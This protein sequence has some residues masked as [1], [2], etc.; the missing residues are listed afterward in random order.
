LIRANEHDQVQGSTEGRMS[1]REFVLKAVGAG[2]AASS[3]GTLLT[4]C[5][6]GL[7]TDQKAQG[8]SITMGSSTQGLSKKYS[9]QT[10]AVALAITSAGNSLLKKFTSQTGIK[11]KWTV[12]GWDAL[13]NKITA[14]ASADTYF[15]DV[16]D[17]DWSRVGLYARTKWFAPLKFSDLDTLKKDVPQLDVFTVDGQLVGMPNDASIMVTTVNTKD[18]EQAGIEKMPTT[19]DAYENALKDIQKA[20]VNAHPLGI[21]FAA[22]EG[23]STYWYQLTGGAFGGRILSDSFKP[24]FTDKSSAGYRAM[25]WMVEQYKSGMV[26]K[27]YINVT[28]SSEMQSGMALHKLSSIFSDYSGNVSTLYNVPSQSKVTGQI[29]Y[30]PTPGENGIGQNLGNPDGVGI[31]VTARRKGAAAQFIKWYTSTETQAKLAG[32]YGPVETG[33]IA[34]PM[35]LSSMK[36]LAKNTSAQ[37]AELLELFRDN[38]RPVFPG[39]PP[40]WYPTFSDAVYTNIHS[41]ALGQKTVAQAIK[42]IARTVSKEGD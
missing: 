6:G 18:F 23:L 26:P 15:A 42:E 17:V 21:P 19:F 16:T 1:R 11:V 39:G 7:T 8:Q 13:Q 35:R 28:D 27:E 38:S 22:A 36:I 24:L 14:A 41:A 33:G 32:A 3:V 34:F 9:G 29:K 5:G 10:I 37:G 30:L 12:F 40:P 4:A 31:P 20:G 2:F 25:E